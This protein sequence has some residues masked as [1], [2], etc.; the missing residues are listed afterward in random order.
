MTIATK[1]LKIFSVF[2]MTIGVYEEM[3]MVTLFKC[4]N[5]LKKI[6]KNLKITTS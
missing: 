4:Q 5:T 3:V 6:W 1:A 2:W